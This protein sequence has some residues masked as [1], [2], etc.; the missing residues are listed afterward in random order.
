MSRHVLGVIARLAL[1]FAVPVVVFAVLLDPWRDAEASAIADILGN[2]GVTGASTAFGYRIL[3]LPTDG[4]PFLATISPS[5]SALAALLAFASI[6]VFLVR[7]DPM[8]R[9]LAFVAAAGI[10]LICNMVRIGL[11]IYVG[12]E[13]DVN[14]LVAFHDWVGTAFGLLYVLGGFTVYL[15]VLLPSNRRLLAEY[16]QA[17][18]QRQA[19]L[20]GPN[21]P[22]G[23][24]APD[25]P[26]GTKGAS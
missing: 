14:G 20:D 18:E 3:V 26:P 1:T 6:S 12:L 11:S 21:G 16:R 23:S 10:V 4:A 9:F 8:R 5:C 13:T 25:G 17:R 22:N 19:Q 2:L 24:G 15:W 7:G